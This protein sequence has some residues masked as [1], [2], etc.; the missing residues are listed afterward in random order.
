MTVS[1]VAVKKSNSRTYD[2]ECPFLALLRLG[3]EP[4]RR[5]SAEKKVHMDD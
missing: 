1:V 2:G 5:R 3:R 4:D